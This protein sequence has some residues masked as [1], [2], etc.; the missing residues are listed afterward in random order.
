MVFRHTVRIVRTHRI[1]DLEMG[2][3]C[4]FLAMT[5]SNRRDTKRILDIADFIDIVEHQR[6]VPDLESLKGLAELAQRGGGA[7]IRRMV[8]DIDAGQST[9]LLANVRIRDDGQ[10][11]PALR[12]S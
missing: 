12:T 8:T 1:P 5:S 2:L 11:R 9:S 6:N 10:K 4:K 3:V 7:K